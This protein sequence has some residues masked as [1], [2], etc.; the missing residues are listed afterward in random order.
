M[1]RISLTL[2]TATC[3]LSGSLSAAGPNPNHT[4][5][6]GGGGGEAPPYT[7]I[8][9]LPPDLQTVGSQ[10]TDLNE[11]GQAV[12]SA[13]LYNGLGGARA[14]HLDVAAGVYTLLSGGSVARGINNLNQTVGYVELP[15][16]TEALF[17][18]GPT[19]DPVS[20][21]PLPGDVDSYAF[22]INDDGIVV[23]SSDSQG[24]AWRVVVDEG[25][26]VHVSDPVALTVP[27]GVTEWSALD[28]GE[29]VNGAAVAAGYV[30]IDTV[31][32]ATVWL[33]E[34]D[35]DD[36]T[37]V[38]TQPPVGLGQDSFSYAT[39][40]AGDVC[41]ESGGLPF[42]APAD[43]G[44]QPLPLPRNTQ[45]GRALGMSNVGEVVG[46]LDIYRISRNS[47]DGPGNFHAYLW[48]GGAIIDL[49]TQVDLGGWDRLWAANVIN[50]AGIIAGWGRFDVESRGFVMVPN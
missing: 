34:F 1:K 28:V 7:I 17:W 8:P 32:E 47:A 11:T 44:I 10:V 5:G 39:N 23:G 22:A 48:S 19:A 4:T 18:S 50:D 27:A 12:G 33:L 14:V 41:G 45:S 21:P 20:L 3:L 16:V 13:D 15:D 6:G 31:Q 49:E 42:I 36:G 37:I 40:T 46:Q 30:A 2:L 29:T 26:D 35:P 24:V 9:F 38:I 43:Q 25:G